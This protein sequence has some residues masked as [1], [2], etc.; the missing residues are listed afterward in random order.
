M[1]S[2]DEW[3]PLPEQQGRPF[4]AGQSHTVGAIILGG[5][6]GTRLRPLT[7]KRAKPA[8]PIGGAYRLIDVPMSNCLNCG[9]NKIYILT[10][11]NSTS[12]NRHLSRTYNTAGP[13][14]QGFVEVLAASQSPGDTNWCVP[15]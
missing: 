13:V 12:L 3:V 2:V 7:S 9:I 8:V 4:Q 1:A 11:Y 14:S 5:G 6:A 10:Q 15:T